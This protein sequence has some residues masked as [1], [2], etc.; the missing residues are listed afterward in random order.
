MV[1]GS[2]GFL[3]KR[4]GSLV[5]LASTTRA[6]ATT[7][8][9]YPGTAVERLEAVHA[10]VATLTRDELSGPWPDVRRRL[11]WAGGLKDLEHVAPGQG[12]TGHAFNDYNHC[13]LTTMLGDVQDESNANGEVRL[14]SR[15]NLLGP[16]IR[17][18]SDPD[19]GPGGS[20]S[21]CTNGCAA[22]PPRDV[23]HVQFRSKI[24]FKL[25]WSPADAYSSFV[26]VDDD[27]ALLASG[28]PQPPLPDLRERQMNFQVVQGS[29]YA[30][31]AQ[32]LGG[33]G[34]PNNNGCL[35]T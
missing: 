11:L 7:T 9:A 30:Q 16:G 5:L 10:R 29:K 14:I 3:F 21:T 26:L 24:A 28:T 20:W 1:A 33:G 17:I 15:R 8:P 12:Y 35:H 32:A 19:L 22:D 2:V 34:E 13:D 25:V 6:M 31:A 18:A 4:G 27:G 23:A